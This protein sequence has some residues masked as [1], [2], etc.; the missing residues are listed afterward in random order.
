MDPLKMYFL[1]KI[2]IFHCYASLP[3]G[4]DKCCRLQFLLNIS[5]GASKKWSHNS[6]MLM[7]PW[8]R[9]QF[10]RFSPGTT[11]NGPPGKGDVI[12][13]VPCLFFGGASVD[14]CF[15]Q[16]LITH[17]YYQWSSMWHSS[18]LKRSAVCAGDAGTR[19]FHVLKFS[20][21]SCEVWDLFGWGKLENYRSIE[22]SRN[23]SSRFLEWIRWLPMA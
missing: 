21:F 20:E 16:W 14:I 5:F 4:S 22:D 12:F 17:G 15:A 23:T 13:Q 10:Q 11:K 7:A 2:V 19:C 6:Q 3:E 9:K 1:L 8:E 18:T